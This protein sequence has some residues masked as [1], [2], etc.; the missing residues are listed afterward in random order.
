MTPLSTHLRIWVRESFGKRFHITPSHPDKSRRH[1]GPERPRR[2]EAFRTRT[3]ASRSDIADERGIPEADPATRRALREGPPRAVEPRDR[4]P[5]P[6]R[7][8]RPCTD[9]GDARRR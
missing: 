9:A 7:P 5:R 4:A 6:R 8:A 1:G 3:A 2:A